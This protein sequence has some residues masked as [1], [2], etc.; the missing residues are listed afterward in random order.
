MNRRVFSRTIIL[1]SL[2]VIPGVH[3]WVINHLS[4]SPGRGLLTWPRSDAK[5]QDLHRGSAPGRKNRRIDTIV[6][7]LKIWTKYPDGSIAS[8][9]GSFQTMKTHFKKAEVLASFHHKPPQCWHIC[10]FIL[11]PL[12]PVNKRISLVPPVS[13]YRFAPTKVEGKSQSEEKGLHAR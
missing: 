5:I 12:M 4:P 10:P 2:G 3:N 8:H 9:S 11:N 7:T 13:S 1:I 6:R